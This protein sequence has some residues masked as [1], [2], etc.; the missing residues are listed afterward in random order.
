MSVLVGTSGF[1][2]KDWVGPV[3]P[4]GLDQKE[5]LSFYARQ[6][7]TCEL[8]FSYYRIPDARTLDRMA[9]K[10]PDG[11]LFSV[12]AFRGITHERKDPLPQMKQFSS[13]LQPLID[14]KKFAC[15]LVQFPYSFHDSEANRAYLG[16]VRE[17]FGDLPL[18]VE[19]RSREWITEETFDRL[20]SLDL[21]Y[22]CVDQP[23]FKNLVPP[24]AEATGPV[25]YVRFHGR[26]YD[27]WWKHDEAWERYDYTYSDDELQ[28]WVPKIRELDSAAPLTLVYMNNHW[29]GQAVGAANQLQMLLEKDGAN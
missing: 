20:R 17:G 29:Q 21:G 18:V 14:S 5:W 11:F 13:A 9:A 3:Y 6:F 16:Q 1:H 10:V 26:N 24:V 25:A 23:R 4:E 19:F 8:N 7:P 28:E 22:C 27:K 12:K 15:V 2:Y